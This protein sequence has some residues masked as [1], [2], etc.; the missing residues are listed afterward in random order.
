ML[1]FF[2]HESNESDEFLAQCS[3]FFSLSQSSSLVELAMP[4]SKVRVIGYAELTQHA[5]TGLFNLK[6]EFY[7]YIPKALSSDL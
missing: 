2:D 7:S 6:L 3:Q 1:F 4:S 5:S